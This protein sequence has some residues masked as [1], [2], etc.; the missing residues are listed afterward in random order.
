MDP[1][2]G[3]QHVGADTGAELAAV[4]AAEEGDVGARRLVEQPGHTEGV[5][6]HGDR[7]GPRDAGREGEDRGR[8][9][10]HDGAAGPDLVG[11]GGAQRL[12]H[13]AVHADPEAGGGLHGE[14]RERRGPAAFLAQQPAFGELVQVAVHGREADPEAS[15]EFV[16]AHFSV[17][18][19]MSQYVLPSPVDLGQRRPC[20]SHRG[21]PFPVGQRR[22]AYRCG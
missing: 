18:D 15:G 7:F 4:A 16:D 13:R 1:A 12:L 3:A 20:G 2:E 17:L 8:V 14:G 6:D 11:D 21:R 9:V 22:R 19:D 5:G 10:Q